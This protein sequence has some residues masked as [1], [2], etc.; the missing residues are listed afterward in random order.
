MNSFKCSLATLV[1]LLGANAVCA[2]AQEAMPLAAVVAKGDSL[3]ND[4][5]F[6][7]AIS[8]YSD[9]IRL[10]PKGVETGTQLVLTS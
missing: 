9:A 7:A 3:R 5:D 10:N 8:A 1:G 4:D 6:E 2:S